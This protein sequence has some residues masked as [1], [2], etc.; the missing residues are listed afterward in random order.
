MSTMAKSASPWPAALKR[1]AKRTGKSQRQL[2]AEAGVSLR[3]WR[4]WL[5][6]DRA[7]SPLARRAL[8]SKFGKLA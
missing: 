1:L 6:E 2:A 5:Y 7:P 3:T 8:E 4:S